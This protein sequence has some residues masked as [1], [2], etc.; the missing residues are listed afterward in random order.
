[1]KRIM[2]AFI[3]LLSWSVS[4]VA[5]AEYNESNVMLYFFNRI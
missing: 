2:L 5:G 3:I 4:V 1:M